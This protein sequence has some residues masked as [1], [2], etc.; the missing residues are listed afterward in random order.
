MS[1]TGRPAFAYT[2]I[3]S[4]DTKPQKGRTQAAAPCT[5]TKHNNESTP[6]AAAVPLHDASQAPHTTNAEAAAAPSTAQF[7]P[8]GGRG[9]PQQPVSPALLFDIER[10]DST[11]SDLGLV[12]L[13]PQSQLQSPEFIYGG[14]NNNGEGTKLA[15]PNNGGG[16]FDMPWGAA[17]P[18]PLSSVGSAA[19]C[20]PPESTSS[21]M[22][23]VP[24]DFASVTES[25][26]PLHHC[27]GTWSSCSRDPSPRGQSVS[28]PPRHGEGEAGETAGP[29]K[30]EDTGDE[31]VCLAFR[32][33][34]KFARG[35]DLELHARTAHEHVCLWGRDG[36]CDH[37]GF[38]T[39]A[40]L[41]WHVKREHLLICP[42][43]GCKD[44][45]FPSAEVVDCHLKYVHGG[46]KEESHQDG[47][48]PPS[49]F[50]PAPARPAS[51]PTAAPASAVELKKL[52]K[53]MDTPD[54]RILKMNLSI[55][56]SKKR[57]REQL[58]AVLVKRAKRANG[59]LP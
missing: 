50:L 18:R 49:G 12:S 52:G 30:Q 20:S 43:L 35:E 22:L 34:A 10:R 13:N 4:S 27:D 45:A 54:D 41:N 23:S 47:A 57:C 24:I 53:K 25:T 2:P 11:F 33:E 36:P 55:G 39:R 31:Y 14:G 21:G 28:V 42:V 44:S 40:E 15:L 59:K 9:F 48:A 8:W 51:P 19:T 38:A 7:L 56:T 3:A 6:A 29:G 5:T 1:T 16:L 37:P 26:A 58:R 32:C 17:P 46:L